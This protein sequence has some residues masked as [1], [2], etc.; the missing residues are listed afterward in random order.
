MKK[1]TR[2]GLSLVAAILASTS[3]TPAE[4]QQAQVQQQGTEAVKEN[5][6]FEEIIVTA[7]KRDERVQTVP[8]AVSVL[9]EQTIKQTFAT[10]LAGISGIVPNVI[11][12]P[13]PGYANGAAFAIRGLSFQDPDASFEPAVGVVL[14]GVYL[15]KATAALLDMYDVKSVEILRGPQG[16]LFGKNTIGGLVNITTKRP[17]GELHA[18]IQGT[19]GNYGRRDGKAFIEFP[20]GDKVAVKISGLT[21]NMDGY[22]RNAADNY[23]R[24]GAEDTKAGRLTLVFKPA[25]NFDLTLIGDIVRDQGDAAPQKNA[26]PPGFVAALIGYPAYTDDLFTVHL[27]GLNTIDSTAKGIVAEA[28]WRLGAHTITSVT[29][30]R[31]TRDDSWVDLDGDAVPLFEYHRDQNIKQFSEEL[32][33]ASTW[34]DKFDSVIGVMYFRQIYTQAGNQIVDCNLIFACPFPVPVGTIPLPLMSLAHQTGNTYAGFAQGNYHV[35]PKVRITLGGRYSYEDKNIDFNPPGYNFYPPAF[36]PFVSTGTHFN[37]F[38]PRVGID[39]QPTDKAML[40]ASFSTGFKAGGYN[41]RSNT[42]SGIGPYKDEKVK[43]FEVGAKTDW[44]DGHLRANL[45]LF[46]NDYSDMQVEVIVPSPVASGEETQVR[47][48]GKSY[49]EGAELELMALPVHGLKLTAN[50]GYLKAKYTEFMADVYGLGYATDNTDLKLRRAPKWTVD[51]GFNYNL[52]VGSV[53]SLSFAGNMNYTAEYE[54][55]VLNDAFARRPGATLFNGSVA[56]EPDSGKFRVSV[57]G[58]NL[59]N[60]RFINNGINGGGLFAFNSPN[61]PRVFGVELEVKF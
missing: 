33:V 18:G 47:N 3:L 23:K 24:I 58:K 60:K 53:G 26:S 16:T 17:S 19:F 5:L 14:D 30:Y 6:A 45:A 25:D 38:T 8:V 15:S 56:F 43:S 52:P 59:T 34:N 50:I 36:A 49:T 51:L 32:R 20:V 13:A 46:Y 40:Y 27:D 57:F 7:R 28:N 10:D 1:L 31:Q 42:L 22:F 4:A 55:D 39:Y 48:V 41:G 29:G 35:T 9:T 37:N 2:G 44:L 11:L 54:T 21:K 12:D 61:R